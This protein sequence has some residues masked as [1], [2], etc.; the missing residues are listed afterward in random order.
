MPPARPSK[1]TVDAVND[2]IGALSD[3]LHSLRAHAKSAARDV[4]STAVGVKRSAKLAGRSAMKS[5]KTAMRKAEAGG[6]GL[7]DKAA[8]V[9]H[10][11]TGTEAAKPTRAR[12]TV[13]T[14][15]RKTKR[16]TRA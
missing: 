5:G 9:W 11:I 4:K 15:K 13:A 10:D 8:K 14:R 16:K 2:A 3:L 6:E 12:S 1:P 7:L